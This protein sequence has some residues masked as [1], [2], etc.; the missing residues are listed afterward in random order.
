MPKSGHTPRNR[1]RRGQSVR[2]SDWPPA[3]KRG[4][5][6]HR[7]LGSIAGNGLTQR[8]K[9]AKESNRNQTGPLRLCVMFLSVFRGQA[10]FHAT[11][12]SV[13]GSCYFGKERKALFCR[14]LAGSRRTK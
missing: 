7:V 8:R 1:V 5:R 3:G 13:P 9:D 2:M 14:R 4:T 6:I 11:L 12:V 10:V